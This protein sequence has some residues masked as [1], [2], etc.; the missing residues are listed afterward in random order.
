MENIKQYILNE[1]ANHRLS[2]EDGK[3][4]LLNLGK[5]E[6]KDI[7]I[8][9]LACEF[10]NSKNKYEFFENIEKGINCLKRFSEE[11][12]EHL[13]PIN[14]NPQILK[15]FSGG[16]TQMASSDFKAGYIED[17]EAFDA[18][19]FGV[20]PREAA[21]MDPIQRKC[22]Q[23]CMEALEDAGYGGDKI[24]N[25]DT[26]VYVGRDNTC[27]T[28]YRYIV[29]DD[30]MLYT[31]TWEGIL[32]SRINYIYNLRGPAMVI[33]T[34]CS[35]GLVAIHTAVHAIRNK[36]CTMAIAGGIAL[37]SSPQRS[38]DDSD[39][40]LAS[41]QA[42][43]NEIRSFDKES[44]GT[45][46]GEGVGI[47]V[48]KPL[49]DALKDHDHIYAVIKGSAINN[50]GASNGI[51][52][53]NPEAQMEVY[54][55]AWKDAEI[56]PATIDYVEAHGTGT[57]LGD[58]IEIKSLTSAF[59]KY[60]DNKQFCGIGT[61]K[62]NIG[63]T[64]GAAGVAGLIK[65]IHCLKNKKLYGSINFSIP[66]PHIDFINGP[67]YMVDHTMDWEKEGKRRAAVSAFGFCGT[68]A[69]LVVEEYEQPKRKIKEM[70]QIFT[71]SAKSEEAL[72]N[73]VKAYVDFYKE[74]N[75]QNLND[76]CYTANEGR[77]QYDYRLA[78]YVNSKTELIDRL[79]WIA[80]NGLKSDEERDIIYGLHKV[81]SEKKKDPGIGEITS[82][83]K[84]ELTARNE[85]ILEELGAGA[86]SKELFMKLAKNYILGSGINWKD[87]YEKQDVL[88]V[89]I[90][91]Y[92]YDKTYYW[93][94]PRDVTL[95]GSVSMGKAV[96]DFYIDKLLLSTL[97]Q[98]VYATV[99]SAKKYWFIE[100]HKIF[101]KK[102]IPGAAYPDM[103]RHIAGFYYGDVPLEFRDMIF[104]TPLI[105]GE[106]E[107]EG[108]IIVQKE[109]DHLKIIVAS[110]DEPYSDNPEWITHVEGRVYI[111]KEDMPENLDVTGLQE[112]M[113]E[114][115]LVFMYDTT[116]AIGFGGRWDNVT[117]LYTDEKH[118]LGLSELNS[119]YAKD[120]EQTS[121]HAA[122]LDMAVNAFGSFGLK[123]EMYL[124]FVYKSI[125]YYRPLQGKLLSYATKV[126]ESSQTHTY[127][128][129]ISDENGIPC[130][131]IKEYTMKKINRVEDVIGSSNVFNAVRWLEKPETP[132]KGHLV[133]GNILIIKDEK[134]KSDKLA[135]RF[136]RVERKVYEVTIGDTYKEADDF[137]YQID[138]TE[139]NY[140]QLMNALKEKNINY[141]IHMSSLTKCEKIENLEQLNYNRLRGI[142]SLFLTIKS[143]LNSKISMNP[144][145]FC[146]VENAD[147]VT[148][149]ETVIYPQNNSLGG[150]LKCVHYEYPNVISK[151]ADIDDA[152][153]VNEVIDILL[154]YE[155]DKRIAVRDGR[156][157][158]EHL[159]KYSMSSLEEEKITY[160]EEGAYIITGG[161]GGMGSVFAKY[162]ADKGNVNLCL[163][164]TRPIDFSD[165]T[166][167]KVQLIDELSEKCKDVSYY[168]ADVSNYDEMKQVIDNIRSKY[169]K[170]KGVFHCAGVAGNGYMISKEESV[171]NHVIDPKYYGTWII[172]D[173][174]KE[175][176]LEI[177]YL[178]S[179]MNTVLGAPGS[180]D[181]TAANAYLDSFAKARALQGK[182]TISLN[183]P[184][185]SE[186]GMAAKENVDVNYGLFS[187]VDNQKAILVLEE[188]IRKNIIHAVPGE[189][190]IITSIRMDLPSILNV[191]LKVKQALEQ[192]ERRLRSDASGN[193]ELNINDISVEGKNDNSYTA[194]EIILGKIFGMIL[195]IKNIDIYDHISDL[196]ADSIIITQIFKAVDQKYKGAIDVADIFM[197]NSVSELAEYIVK[198]TEK[199]KGDDLDTLTDKLLSGQI[200]IEN[201][202]SDIAIMQHDFRK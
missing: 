196:G 191:P 122:M 135:E 7:A 57:K 36:E 4:L 71:I 16:E 37:G 97:T 155:G 140:I 137:N 184:G 79:S 136:R 32:A 156:I 102:M 61:V 118:I 47:V 73:T 143:M 195:G 84:R 8:I 123:N 170:I 167:T 45:I 177:F 60:T 22:L 200:S 141:I 27:P 69:H 179:S 24:R 13:S 201:L 28:F 5:A 127:N 40:V 34:A 113:H 104:Y 130:L 180:N 10:S 171:F 18:K 202:T 190:N 176:D 132:K 197:Y 50:D 92:Q 75:D 159:N 95:E 42:S 54:E 112:K 100:E 185:W 85:E 157:Y 109:A 120:F 119:K 186:V 17:V 93:G 68:N 15:F 26:G 83:K 44:T 29:Q 3:E 153:D 41:V 188:A 173:L 94:A 174:T 193:T 133:D 183:W 62:T 124:P 162:L 63:H 169:G 187:P 189:L 163:L 106:G 145:I 43:T 49:N 165:K 81:I 116:K 147:A 151:Y 59:R 115:K 172:D 146:L 160:S 58:P 99:F 117:G 72:L 166:N 76:I 25:T 66:N 53:P 96:D 12:V 51:S 178:A 20:P 154:G 181:Y 129:M 80:D 150:I 168:S 64:V 88:K 105:T 9:G 142:N 86:E 194:T 110:A 11:R 101:G 199:E 23:S 144:T 111:N 103:F 175:D 87:Y 6:S 148:E 38:S 114:E 91:P 70:P 14:D 52:A 33:D 30:P 89:S 182:K 19:F 90:P 31:G 39:D 164:G 98:D 107:R 35:S 74:E 56:D 152:A 158:E 48:L 138:G 67:M 139:A 77:G 149:K 126:G 198:K 65:T 108:Q 21:Y 125:K 78:L 192:E 131:E 161:T 1:I 2:K 55:K 46:F 82:A 121:I 128:Y 134:G